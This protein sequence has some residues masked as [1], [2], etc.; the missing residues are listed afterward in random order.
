MNCLNN[1]INSLFT[2]VCPNLEQNSCD[3]AIQNMK[4]DHNNADENILLL[5]SRLTVLENPIYRN[6]IH[7][8]N[9]SRTS[10]KTLQCRYV[11]YNSW[12]VDYRGQLIVHDHKDFWMIFRQKLSSRT[13]VFHHCIEP[14]ETLESA[15]IICM[16]AR[17][18]QLRSFI[19][20]CISHNI[21]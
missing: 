15:I 3:H 19:I 9:C 14:W 13:L 4:M 2:S 5:L 10:E 16:N 17:W 8:L 12:I 21:M 11:L 6:T 1:N 20:I 18:T 7:L